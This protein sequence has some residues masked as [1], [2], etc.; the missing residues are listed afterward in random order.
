MPEQHNENARRFIRS[1][2]EREFGNNQTAFARRIGY[3]Q[4]T[5]NEFLNGGR[6]AG[7]KLLDSVA[8]LTGRSVDQIRGAVPMSESEGTALGN[9]HGWLDAEAELRKDMPGI[10]VWVIEKARAIRNF[11]APNP[12]TKEFV[13]KVVNFVMDATPDEE[14][15]KYAMAEAE[16]RAKT[17]NAAAETRAKRRAK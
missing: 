2:I 8:Q 4:P 5:L 15:Y 12:V 6:G 3:A 7:F 1:L 16:A 11:T 10:P 13:L 9:A 17:I 14:K